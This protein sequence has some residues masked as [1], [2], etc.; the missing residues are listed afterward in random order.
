MFY[1]NEPRN[2]LFGSTSCGPVK[3]LGVP[4]EDTLSFR[5]GTR[6]APGVLRLITPYVEA[7]PT[8]DLGIDPVGGICDLGDVQLKQGLVN[9]NLARVVEV[10]EEVLRRGDLV[11]NIGGEHTLSLAVARAIGRAYGSVGAFIQFDAHLDLRREW[12]PGQALSHATFARVLLDELRPTIYVNVGFRGYDREEL[13]YAQSHGAIL[14]DSVEA[15]EMSLG[16]FYEVLKPLDGVKGPVHLSIDLDVLDPSVAPGVG[17]PEEGGLSYLKLYGLLSVVIPMVADRLR[18]VD[19]V[20]YSPPNDVSNITA[21]LVSRLIL[22]AA[23][24]YLWSRGCLRS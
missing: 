6:F 23:N 2:P 8:E 3:V 17:N 9:D 19:I 22:D 13:E 15:A 7:N 20:E 14:V 24:L 21:V 5:P 12:P 10:E 16:E 4:M 18:A 11:I 1:V